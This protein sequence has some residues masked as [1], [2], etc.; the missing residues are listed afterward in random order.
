MA[1]R[2]KRHAL[3]ELGRRIANARQERERRPGGEQDHA[4]A[5]SGLGFGLRLATEMVAALIVG[6]GLGLALDHWLGTGP[7]LLIVFFV[8]GSAAGLMNVIRVAQAYDAARRRER[9]AREAADGA[10][11]GDTTA[12]R[13]RPAEADGHSGD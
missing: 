11:A 3:D 6:V 12:P 13:R 8:L 7:W 2:D 4:S 1:D 10:N 9:A 5:S